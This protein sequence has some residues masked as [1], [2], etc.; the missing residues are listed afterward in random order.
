MKTEDTE[1]AVGRLI[2]QATFVMSSDDLKEARR[3]LHCGEYEMALECLILDLSI[4]S[5]YP[6]DLDINEWRL[7]ARSCKLNEGGV[8]RDDIWHIMEKWLDAYPG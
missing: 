3:L 1:E 4:A 8:I 2:E 5:S 6:P 7:V